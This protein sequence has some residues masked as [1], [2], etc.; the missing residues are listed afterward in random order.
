MKVW[1]SKYEALGNDFIIIDLRVPQGGENFS[2]YEF[3]KKYC[4]R[5]FG[6]GADGVITLENPSSEEFDFKMRI[7][8]SDGSEAEM[9][10]NGIRCLAKY[11]YDMNLIS[12]DS[13]VFETKAGPRV[14]KKV[15]DNFEVDMGKPKIKDKF[16]LREGD[17]WGEKFECIEVDV[18]NPHVVI[19]GDYPREV[20]LSFAPQIS[21]SKNVN[22]EFA[23]IEDKNVIKVW[24]WE[25]GVGETL[26]CGTG[27]VAVFASAREKKLIKNEAEISFKGGNIKVKQKDEKVFIEGGANFVFSGYVEI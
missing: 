21:K 3:A 13:V 25:R 1:F 10:G 8:N 22:V 16:F 11:V 18:G 23:K 6:I 9:S 19:F 7:I 20:F 4:E 15:Q 17:N 2:P 24:V 12:K 5:R 27:A 26:A 14:V